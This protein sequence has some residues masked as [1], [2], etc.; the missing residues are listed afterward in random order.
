MI[1]L[2]LGLILLAVALAFLL[3]FR[4]AGE[5]WQGRLQCIQDDSARAR[6][7]MH[8]LT[9]HVFVAMAERAGQSPIRTVVGG[10]G[11]GQGPRTRQG[12]SGSRV[13]LDEPG[14]GAASA[15]I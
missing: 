8:E 11:P 9:K 13:H 10:G 12:W 2:V 15:E 1:V 14:A 4:L 3:G 7:E 5:G 6:R